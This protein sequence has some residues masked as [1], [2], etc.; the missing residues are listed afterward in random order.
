MQDS[1]LA[2]WTAR[3]HRSGLSGTRACGHWHEER[4]L[5]VAEAAAARRSIRTYAPEPIPEADLRGI[6]HLVSLAPSA[7]NVQ[8]W[9]FVVAQ[10]PDLKAALQEAAF[11]QRQIGSA[12]AVIV[13]YS[14]M[15][16]TLEHIEDVVHPGIPDEQRRATAE[17][18]RARFNAMADDE[19]EQWGEKQA[20]I[21]LGYLLL[22]ARSLGY[23][24]SAML[25][26][27]PAK[28][29]EV[30]GLPAHVRIPSLVAIGRGTEEGFP[31][32]R[33]SVGRIATFR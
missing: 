25:G 5:T 32:H 22:A 21:A 26:F 29:K 12:P 8:P 14:D 3:Q 7:F 19:R 31:H 24:T 13:L 1:K 18:L 27:N 28:V 30:L 4:D 10:D 20:N 9:R 11:G 15:H 23:D 16:D 2:R 6:L 33:H 17:Q